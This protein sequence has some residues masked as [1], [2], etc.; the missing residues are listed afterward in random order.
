MQE[1]LFFMGYYNSSIDGKWGKNTHNAFSKFAQNKNLIN[2]LKTK[3][4]SKNIIKL[5]LSN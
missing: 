5:L 3:S 4:G 2:E 1:K